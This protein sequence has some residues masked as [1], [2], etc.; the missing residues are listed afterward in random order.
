MKILCP[1]LLSFLQVYPTFKMLY[2]VW[3]F[4]DIEILKNRPQLDP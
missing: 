3:L 4:E 1:S 2:L